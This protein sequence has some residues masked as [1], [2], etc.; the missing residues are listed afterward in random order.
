[1]IGPGAGNGAG[2]GGGAEREIAPTCGAPPPTDGPAG[3][4]PICGPGENVP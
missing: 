2:P 1:M 4:P 3:F